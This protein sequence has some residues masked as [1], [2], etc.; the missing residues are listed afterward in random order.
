MAASIGRRWRVAALRRRLL[1]A[2][3]AF[4][5]VL[6]ALSVLAPSDPRREPVVVAAQ[7]LPAGHPVRSSDMKIA[8]LPQAVVPDGAAS[9]V[10][11]LA[12]RVLAGALRRGEPLT[13]VRLVGRA[14]LAGLAPG[15]VAV[16]VR[17]ADVGMLTL[18]EPG[19]RV[20]VLA[21]V[22]A[23]SPDGSTTG[24]SPPARVVA[25]G[26]RVLTVP[27]ASPGSG[28]SGSSGSSSLIGGSSTST[29]SSTTGAGP[30]L[31]LA[32]DRATAAD[33]A[34]AATGRLSLQLSAG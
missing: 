28:S 12:G 4:V 11:A 27:R 18:V 26:A 13:D 5:A 22:A 32:V 14:L 23:A 6:L 16:P 30:P 33:L 7:D 25:A 34:G 21:A 10:D 20:D 31:L 24:V 8:L 17:L 9:S 29:G 19:D 2:G 3:L 15:R 1:A